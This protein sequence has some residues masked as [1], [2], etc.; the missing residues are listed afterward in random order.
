MKSGA[1]PVRVLVVDDSAE[2]ARAI[3]EMVA[4]TPG[5]VLAGTAASGPEALALQPKLKA[6]LV[7]L[8]VRMPEL[9]GIETAR[10]MR[11]RGLGGVVVLVSAHASA[12]VPGVAEACGAAAFVR[13]S[14]LTLRK[15]AELWRSHESLIPAPAT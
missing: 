7:L 12:D 8:D 13:K 1:R 11:D 2:C 6:D 14:E 4:A 3:G 9:S 5:F 15:L 10:L